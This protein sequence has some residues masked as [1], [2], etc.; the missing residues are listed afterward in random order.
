MTTTTSPAPTVQPIMILQILKF[1]LA[2]RDFEF[3]AKVTGVG[4]ISVEELAVANGWPDPQRAQHAVDV[5]SERANGRSTLPP[6]THHE[7]AHRPIPQPGP[8]RGAQVATD[9]AR[10]V[11]QRL[12]RHKLEKY[13]RQGAAVRARLAELG[14]RMEDDDRKAHAAESKKAAAQAAREAQAK[15]R[16]GLREEVRRL[17]QELAA[18][19]AALHGKPSTPATVGLTKGDRARIR[20]WAQK[21]NLPAPD[22]GR[23]PAATVDAYHAAYPDA[24]ATS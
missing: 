2:G 7:P 3:I 12:E 9:P 4:R 20:Q 1:L 13:R 24:G 6:A 15:H 19:R 18:A 21:N 8:P 5:L 10:T 22:R 23:L 17:E 11:L 16:E 14:T